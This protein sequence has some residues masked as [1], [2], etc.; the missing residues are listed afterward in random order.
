MVIALR[1]PGLSISTTV[2]ATTTPPPTPTTAAS[3]ATIIVCVPFAEDNHGLFDDLIYL[4]ISS[5]KFT[6]R[7]TFCDYFL[8][9]AKRTKIF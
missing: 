9:P 3:A 8:F 4:I 5:R 2:I 6:E 7:R 1:A